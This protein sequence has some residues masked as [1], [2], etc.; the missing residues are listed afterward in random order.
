M[1]WCWG[2][3]VW[4]AR[5]DL[6][7]LYLYVCRKRFLLVKWGWFPHFSLNFTFS[8]MVFRARG[9]FFSFPLFQSSSSAYLLLNLCLIDIYVVDY[10]WISLV[11]VKFSGVFLLFGFVI[12][13]VM[14]SNSPCASPT[15][16]HIQPIQLKLDR[17]NYAF[18]RIL[19]QSA[20][21]AHGFD[22]LVSPT[23]TF[24]KDKS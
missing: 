4:L 15:L 13:I 8:N 6:P 11:F 14:A 10:R 5:I 23:V 24:I 12:F 21:C 9:W 3:I 2:V 17:A 22:D 20:I 19:V 16:P 18:W 1:R 7:F